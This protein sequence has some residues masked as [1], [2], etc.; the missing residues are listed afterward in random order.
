MQSSRSR[1]NWSCLANL[2]RS[3][4]TL[5]WRK[6]R[7]SAAPRGGGAVPGSRTAPWTW[8]G[9][10]PPAGASAPSLDSPPNLST[11]PSSSNLKVI[12]VKS[13]IL[14][15]QLNLNK[16]DYVVAARR[17]SYAVPSLFWMIRLAIGLYTSSRSTLGSSAPGCRKT[18]IAKYYFRDSVKEVSF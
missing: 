17:G 1:C 14:L 12:K 15:N 13:L 7:N 2:H 16:P 5:R 4:V 18:P 10:P 6:T 11:S 8:S 9:G 3:V